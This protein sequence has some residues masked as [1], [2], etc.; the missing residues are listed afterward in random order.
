MNL[1]KINEKQSPVN[2]T[3][4]DLSE[5]SK[6]EKKRDSKNSSFGKR[7]EDRLL[8]ESIWT[9]IKRIDITKRFV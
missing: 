8:F 5:Y 4:K 1:F 2:S 3:V 9:K 7:S 6:S